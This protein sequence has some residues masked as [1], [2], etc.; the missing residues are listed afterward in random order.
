MNGGMHTMASR[1]E[2][3]TNGQAAFVGQSLTRTEDERFLRGKGV[4]VDDV[5]RPGMVHAVVIRSPMAHARITGI[6][7]SAAL[8]APGV[9]AVYTFK[10]IADRSTA[11]PIRLAPLPGFERYLQS[12]L[13]NDRVRYV[14]EPVAVVVAENRY[15][16]EDA[17][18]LVVIDY[19][20]LEPVTSVEGA[21]ADES[22]LFEENGTN[23]ASHYEVS[24]GDVDRAFSEAEYT[25]KERFRCHRHSAVPLETRG[26]VAEWNAS[27]QRLS[28]WGA[29]KVTFFN[30]RA[31]A[32][33]L[34]LDVGQIDM[35]EVDVGGSFGVRGEFY[36][37]DFLV[38]F[39]AMKLGR[40]VKWI[41][42]RREN[43]MATNHS[44][45]MECELE[46]ATRRDGTI[47]GM[48]ARL[49]SDLG[50]YVRTNGGVP[51][52]KA[53]QLLPGPY[54]ISDFHCESFALVTN[55]TPVGTYRGPGRYEANFF[56]ERLFDMV[57]AD[58]GIEPEVFRMK[59]LIRPEELPYE[60]GKLVTYV[61]TTQYDTGNYPDALKQALEAFGYEE[62]K[63][64]RGRLIDG[65]LHG[66]GMACFVESS[67]GGPAES[68]RIVVRGSNSFALYTGV[69]SSG[70]GHE[71]VLAQILAD[72]LGIDPRCVEVFH[73]STNHVE[74]GYGTFHSRAIV[75]GGSAVKCVAQK[76]LD[77]MADYAAA[78]FGISRDAV[79]LRDGALWDAG[80]GTRLIGLDDLV[81]R[82]REGDASAAQ[83][84]EAAGA[85]TNDKLTFSYGAHVTHVAVDP[86]TAQV[87][88]IRHVALED[89]GRA[90]NPLMVNGQTIGAA[91]QGIGAT[92]LDQF[93][94]DET[95]QL[96]TGS[97]ADYL[98]PTSTEIGDIQA[99]TLQD[100]PSK[101]NPLGAK[102]A[103][104]GGIVAT[105]AALANA[106]SDALRGLNVQ[107]TE[108][109]MSL[110]NLSRWIRQ[111]RNQ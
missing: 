33:M 73:G 87:E 24:R 27:S 97:F 5:K 34:G 79:S 55:K 57:A 94:Y 61:P 63:A 41:E 15:L 100:H 9:L 20:P 42:D 83:A 106:V 70:Q 65:K 8:E 14:G 10:D 93:V 107:I 64:C 45:E 81:R 75:M 92:F 91:A 62:L 80:T 98:L 82:A 38:P 7:A 4:Y 25:R 40:P 36:P 88:V 37:E 85:F 96:L 109:P 31:L 46:I 67:G 17:C 95:G 30:R 35:I 111:A 52:A 13:A 22:L 50:A 71:T 3:A 60:V 59:N 11:I 104:E 21:M 102:G 29:T 78:R 1:Q 58:L 74:Q 54:R 12:A 90:I 99:I 19:D 66:I 105:G 110:N 18:E 28:I 68:A 47:L 6:D 2:R 23:V 49:W 84:L 72:E 108:L 39:A 101:L 32:P 16:A 89:I 77:G 103:G 26:L 51:L 56:R 43:L 76:L 48:R 69:S 86:E 53:A 44:R